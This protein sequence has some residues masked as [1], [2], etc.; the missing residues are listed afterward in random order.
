MG[1]NARTAYL[2]A[3]VLSAGTL[4]A[5]TLLQG[6]GPHALVVGL[7]LAGFAVKLALVPAY[8]WLPSVAEHTPALLVGVVIAVMDVTAVAELVALRGSDPG[9]FSP[10]WPWLALALLSAVGGAGLALAQRD[11]K[12]LL[13]FSSVTDAGFIILA[14]TL[15]G[16]FGLAGPCSRRRRMRSARRC[17]SPASPARSATHR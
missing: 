14:V 6:V 5:G 16:R 8:L 4:I 2:V 9:L 15:A 7:L 13:A 10:T 3:L 1:R 12:R 17:S 11:L